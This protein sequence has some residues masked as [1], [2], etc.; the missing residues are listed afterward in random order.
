MYMNICIATFTG[1]KNNTS[2]HEFALP[3]CVLLRITLMLPGIVSSDFAYITMLL[4]PITMPFTK[5]LCA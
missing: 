2:V 4:M 5:T 1:F 3:T